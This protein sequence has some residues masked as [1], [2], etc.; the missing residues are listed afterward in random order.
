MPE[1]AMI[2]LEQER[3]G[4]LWH[5]PRGEAPVLFSSEPPAGAAHPVAPRATGTAPVELS[6]AQPSEDR[7]SRELLVLA[8]PAESLGGPR[9]FL[10]LTV[11]PGGVEPLVLRRV[12]V[13]ASISPP[14]ILVEAR[15][16]DQVDARWRY[17]LRPRLRRVVLG[18]EDPSEGIEVTVLHDVDLAP[19]R[20][21]VTLADG[22]STL[23]FLV[24]SEVLAAARSADVCEHFV[25]DLD[26]QL[27]GEDRGDLI[28][29]ESA[30]AAPL[31]EQVTAAAEAR[32]PGTATRQMG[33]R[34]EIGGREI[35]RGM[36][37]R[38]RHKYPITVVRRDGVRVAATLG[39]VVPG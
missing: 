37:V 6:V 12:S 31:L 10:V 16:G 9:G 15:T 1:Q 4:L 28:W 30:L 17:S 22:W 29:P 27:G 35:V 5:E 39:C 24:D 19:A 2:V 23:S 25:A 26:A 36:R 38:S 3:M 11:G 8:F 32:L 33:L 13:L 20:A 7:H 21:R 18:Q 34:V 14:A